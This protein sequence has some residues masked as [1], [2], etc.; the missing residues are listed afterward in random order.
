MSEPHPVC[1]QL[2]DL[3]KAARLSLPDFEDRHNISGLVLGSYERGDRN[4]P[5]IKLERILNCYGYTLVAIPKDFDAVRLTGNI[6]QEL[7]MI[8]YQL[9]HQ[10]KSESGGNQKAPDR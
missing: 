10:Q 7:R 1:K 3:R 9:E 6:V 4:P 8:A 5:L 2:R